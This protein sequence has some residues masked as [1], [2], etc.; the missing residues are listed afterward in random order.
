M[1]DIFFFTDI[2]GM[3]DLYRAIMS[4]CQE[5]DPE[6]MIIFGGDACDR[7]KDGYKIM[8]ELVDH[9]QVVYLKGNHE[10]MF[11]KAAKEIKQCLKFDV[12]EREKV[13]ESLYWCRGFD[14]RYC[15]IQDSLYN[16]GIE[17]LTDWV[18]DGMN[19]EFVDKIE[20]LPLTFS[21]D[22]C[23]FCHSAS[24]YQ[25][26]ER[27]ADAEYNGFPV[28]RWDAESLI[29]SRSGFTLGWKH[30]HIAV[31]GHTPVP[32]LYDYMDVP[33]TL[34]QPYKWVPT[35][36]MEMDGEKLDMDTGAC[37]TGTAYVL[38]ALTMQAQGFEDTDVNNKE[39]HTHDIKKIECIQL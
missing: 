18:M 1:H 33:E 28:D 15:S 19:M 21:T 27:V 3:Y 37:F 26:F 2:H 14:Y 6:A 8:K 20:H 7:G 10:D 22:V 35:N 4:Y 36:G 31:F 30:N 17:T 24:V 25:T 11:V 32:Y 5:Q 13:R 38:N 16:G 9:P 29:W 39:N 23:D 12:L 34:L